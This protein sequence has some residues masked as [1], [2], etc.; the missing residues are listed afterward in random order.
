MI[1][2]TNHDREVTPHRPYPHLPPTLKGTLNRND[3]FA[4][5]QLKSSSHQIASDKVGDYETAETKLTTDPSPGVG[6]TTTT[7]GDPFFCYRCES[8]RVGAHVMFAWQAIKGFFLELKEKAFTGEGFELKK[9]HL[10]SQHLLVVFC[11]SS[12]QTCVKNG[13]ISFLRTK[14]LEVKQTTS[15]LFLLQLLA[16]CLVPQ[17]VGKSNPPETRCSFFRND[18]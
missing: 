17:A 18:W 12:F 14:N 16:S 4:L 6:R 5:F 7:L 2:V 1:L 13:M 15:K 8:L 11:Y 3:F 10:N 9:S